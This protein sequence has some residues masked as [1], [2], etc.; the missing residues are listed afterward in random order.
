MAAVNVQGLIAPP[1]DP[2]APVDARAMVDKF[3]QIL[4]TQGGKPSTTRLQSLVSGA[5][6]LVD[7][8]DLDALL[9][10]IADHID[11]SSAREAV[12]DG[13]FAKLSDPPS[14]L[15]LWNG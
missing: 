11:R 4:L 9:P 13:L 6:T 14:L 12:R 2:A 1:P 7:D 10:G 3:G 8:L 5:G 15:S